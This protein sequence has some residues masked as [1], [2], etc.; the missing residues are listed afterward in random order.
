NLE[1]LE[2]LCETMLQG[3][4][5]GLGGMTPFPV[6]SALWHFREDFRARVKPRT[7]AT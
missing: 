2:S 3:S 1:L 4:L 6:Q 5:C 7:P